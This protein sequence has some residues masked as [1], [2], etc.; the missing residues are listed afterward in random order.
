MLSRS[1]LPG[2]HTKDYGSGLLSCL[3]YIKKLKVSALEPL[4]QLP[5]S[6]HTNV[7]IQSK[8]SIREVKRRP[9]NGQPLNIEGINCYYFFLSRINRR[10]TY[11]Y[12]KKKIVTI[13]NLVARV[14]GEGPLNSSRLYPNVL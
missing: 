10:A 4:F 2:G 3:R 11:H 6:A 14:Y 13:L 1:G 12:I 9:S 5:R 8:S 7:P